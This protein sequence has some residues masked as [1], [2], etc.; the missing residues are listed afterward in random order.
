MSKKLIDAVKMEV[1]STEPCCREI[2]ITFPQEAVK[3]ETARVLNYIAGVARI[4]G[5][6]PG[7][8]P[9][10]LVSGKFSG[11]ISEELRNRV[12]S[13]TFETMEKDESLD[14]L[15]VNFKAEPQFPANQEIKFTLVANV[16]PEIDLGDYHSMKVE[17]PVDAVTDE[18]IEERVEL[19]RSMYGTYAEVDAPAQA[20]DMLKVSYTSNLE[21]PENPS[22]SLKRRAA[23]E[24]SFIWLNEPESIPGCIAALTGAEKGKEYHFTANF[25]ADFADKELSGKSADYKVKVAAVQRRQKMN[26]EELIAKVHMDSLEKLREMVRHGLESDHAAKRRNQASEAVYARLAETAG[27]FDLPP[28]LLE[29]EIQKELQ[30]VAREQVKS[31][32]DAAK[33]KADVE[34]HRKE[35]E[36]TA[37]EALRRRLILR[38]VAEQEKVSL[39][40]AELDAQVNSMSQYYGYRPKE[41]QEMLRKSGAIDDLKLDM[42]NAKALSAVV[43]VVLQ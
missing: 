2:N 26:D 1:V 38:K 10:A 34:T 23:A 28:A 35:A 24:D 17:L 33:F 27:E 15:S 12:M 41:L 3:T 4:P 29:N 32:E 40:D 22:A 11:E 9:A 19:Y 30:K 43:D 37:R 20:E 31:E 8:A 13:A 21:L 5:F 36:K 25:P 16:A 18:E 14:L 7:K 39:D 6:R 42:L